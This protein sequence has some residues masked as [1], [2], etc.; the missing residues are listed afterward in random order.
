MD[1]EEIVRDIIEA[2]FRYLHGVTEENDDSHSQD[3]P[4]SG[5]DSSQVLPEYN[6]RT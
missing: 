1:Q 3:V 5:R 6:S 2:K 4:S